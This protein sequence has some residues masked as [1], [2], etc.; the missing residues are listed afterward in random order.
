[1]GCTSCG[2]D[3]RLVELMVDKLI[4]EALDDGKIQAGLVSCGD[5]KLEKNTP[6]VT[7]TELRSKVCELIEEGD[8]CFVTPTALS[9]SVNKENTELTDITL[10]MSDGSALTT[11]FKP[12]IS[13]QKA[14]E[15]IESAVSALRDKI[16][17]LDDLKA[18]DIVDG[19]LVGSDLEL[20]KVDGSKITIPLADLIPAAKADRFL[21]SVTYDSAT[22]KLKF[23]V[24]N[25]LDQNTTQ[26]EVSVSDL[27]PVVAG[28]GLEGDGTASNPVKIKIK[29]GEPL[30]VSNDGLAFNRSSSA[31][32]KLVDASGKVQLGYVL[33][34]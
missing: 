4:N 17:G 10:I 18:A 23:T 5:R 33:N 1:M 8:L 28:V 24:A 13:T 22:K 14:E 7:C 2:T 26:L 9:T 20:T 21:Q 12:G 27:L 15:L 31:M 32:A 3:A 16:S 34:I 29:N 19:E 11:K 30:S 6:V 25:D